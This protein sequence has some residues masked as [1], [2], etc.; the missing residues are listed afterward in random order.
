VSAGKADGK[1]DGTA[2]SGGAIFFGGGATAS[3]GG[4]K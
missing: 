2:G 3:S 1:S 4:A